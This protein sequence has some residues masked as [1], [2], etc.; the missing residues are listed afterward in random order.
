MGSLYFPKKKSR[1]FSIANANKQYVSVNITMNWLQYDIYILIIYLL[2]EGL[3]RKINN[4]K[5][6]DSLLGDNKMRKHMLQC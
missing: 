1:L 3:E 6:N 5:L 4:K 2:N